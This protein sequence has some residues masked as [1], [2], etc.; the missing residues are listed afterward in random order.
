LRQNSGCHARSNC[1]GQ[2]Q[3]TTCCRGGRLSILKTT[4]LRSRCRRWITDEHKQSGFHSEVQSM[5]Y[6][7]AQQ[8]QTEKYSKKGTL[9]LSFNQSTLT[10][11]LHNKRQNIPRVLINKRRITRHTLH[12]SIQLTNTLLWWRQSNRRE[13]PASGRW[14]SA[15]MTRCLQGWSPTAAAACLAMIGFLARR[16]LGANGPL[17][18]L[19]VGMIAAA[20]GTP[21]ADDNLPCRLHGDGARCYFGARKGEAGQIFRRQIMRSRAFS[22]ASCEDGRS[23][24]A[25]RWSR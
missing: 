2:Q 15:V 19:S 21:A 8:N 3:S 22:R 25:Y 14:P 4:R 24:F 18:W 23:C 9:I 5:N 12:W 11:E 20:A 17:C 10:T 1:R 6:R 13:S 7:T 16:T